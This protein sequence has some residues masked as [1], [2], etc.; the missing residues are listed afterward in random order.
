MYIAGFVVAVPADRKQDYIEMA[1]TAAS[2]F[3]EHGALRV[4]EGWGDEVDNEAAMTFPKAANAKAGEAT[5]FSWMEFNDKA[6]WKA[7]MAA[8]MND[9]RMQ[10][11]AIDGIMD[12]A[13][14]IYGGFESVL[15]H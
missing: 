8:A 7:C 5:L 3:K 2:L 10:G 15:E 1:R 9:P 12:P 14:V 11:L 4:V 13:R 6:G